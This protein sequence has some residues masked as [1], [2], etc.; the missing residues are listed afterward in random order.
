MKKY[1]IELKWGMIFVIV[2]LIWMYF[3]KFMGWHGENIA[4]HAIYTN[5][6]AIVA[7]FIYVLALLD[8]RKNYYG[9]AMTWMQG[10]LTGLIISVVVAVLSPLSQYIT[11]QWVTPEYFPNIIRYSVESGK[12]SQE[13]A[14]S[15]FN[16]GSYILQSAIFALIVGAVTSAVVAFLVRKKIVQVGS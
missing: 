4:S 16:L 6:F 10:F 15:Y 3:E 13:E 5:F 12:L 14:E 2:S 7:L 8:K 1:A 9:G 11:H